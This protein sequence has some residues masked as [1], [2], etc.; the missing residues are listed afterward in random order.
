MAV[1]V[2]VGAVVA[3]L[4]RAAAVVDRV[5]QVRSPQIAPSSSWASGIDT[6]ASIGSGASMEVTGASTSTAGASMAPGGASGSPVPVLVGPQPTI[7]PDDVDGW[8]ARARAVAAPGVAHVALC[9]DAVD[10][11]IGPPATVDA[12]TAAG[13][14]LETLIAMTARDPVVAIA[15]PPGVAIRRFA[16]D[17]DW[18]A[19]RALALAVEPDTPGYADYLDGWIPSRRAA[20]AV[21]RVRWWGAFEGDAL[22]A[23]AGVVPLGAIA[24]YQDVMT[25]PAHRRR[26]LASAVLA[27]S[28][29][30]THEPS[31]ARRSSASTAS[32]PGLGL[33]CWPRSRGATRPTRS[34]AASARPWCGTPR[35]AGCSARA[36]PSSRPPAATPASP[37]P[38]RRRRA[39]YESAHHARDH[40][41]RAPQG[42]GGARR[43]AGADAGGPGHEGRDRQGR[44]ARG[45]DPER[46]VLMRQFDNPANP[47]IHEST[48]GP[49]I[50]DDTGGKVD[51][52]VAASAPAAPSPGVS[53]YFKRTKGRAMHSWRSSPPTRR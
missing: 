40:E 41:P 50:W 48:T 37:W 19:M 18:Q 32:P 46:Y 30:T 1:A 43:Q 11:V 8:I 7:A 5:V 25:H 26:G 15:P 39:A 35:S 49:E 4:D 51:V 28:S 14:T 20:A 22:V 17:D 10:G 3:L 45:R 52:L 33:R 16:R 12:L 31:G 38:S 9:L 13:F 44:R 47:A 2:V 29:R 21:D 6:G 42:A 53:R 36:R 27:A 24:R 34:S 23:S